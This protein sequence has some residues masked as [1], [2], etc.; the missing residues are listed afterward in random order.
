MENSKTYILNCIVNHNKN[1]LSS[2]GELHAKHVDDIAKIM[3]D[4][5]IE[6][7]V[8]VVKRLNAGE[9]INLENGSFLVIKK[10]KPKRN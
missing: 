7:V 10:S 5:A 3:K 6:T 9:E 2:L 1:G 4:F 8:E